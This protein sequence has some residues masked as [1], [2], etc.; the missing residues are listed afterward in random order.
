MSLKISGF[1]MVF[2]S[3]ISLH[4]LLHFLK[5]LLSL[6]HRLFLLSLSLFWL[7][8]SVSLL[9]DLRSLAEMMI[10]ALFPN[11]TRTRQLPVQI[12]G[13]WRTWSPL[14]SK[15]LLHSMHGRELLH[16]SF[17]WPS[18]EKPDPPHLLTS[19]HP[20]LLP[21]CSLQLTHCSHQHVL[22]ESRTEWAK[23]SLQVYLLA[24]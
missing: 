24:R 4:Y 21:G 18:R 8:F 23:N 14:H 1:K 19:S 22:L 9:S 6:F 20:H 11:T 16:R 17:S 7:V 10:A 12:K 3:I 5:N 13:K 2:S 15:G